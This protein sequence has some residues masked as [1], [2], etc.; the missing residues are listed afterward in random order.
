MNDSNL[1]GFTSIE[2]P[3]KYL[4]DLSDI[5]EKNKGYTP[6]GAFLQVFW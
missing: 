3:H 6:K 5:A 2:T 4:N 1:G